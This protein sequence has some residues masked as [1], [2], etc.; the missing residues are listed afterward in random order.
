MKKEIFYLQLVVLL[1]LSCVS[2][3]AQI[4]DPL[5]DSLHK[6]PGTFS[7]DSSTYSVRI[8]NQGTDDA[9]K[10]NPAFRPDRMGIR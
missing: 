2:A 10:G 7:T 4:S 9:P 8:G 5:C 3:K 1:S 6:H